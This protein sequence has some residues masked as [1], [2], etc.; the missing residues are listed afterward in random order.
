MYRLFAMGI[1]FW[2]VQHMWFD[3]SKVDC[4]EGMDLIDFITFFAFMILSAAYGTVLLILVVCC[5]F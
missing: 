1:W 3:F 2:A 4:V 5:P